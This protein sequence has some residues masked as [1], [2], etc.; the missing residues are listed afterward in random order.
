MMKF[1][2]VLLLIICDGLMIGLMLFF[3]VYY[4]FICR[5]IFINYDLRDKYFL[6][7]IL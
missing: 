2:R 6:L 1:C 4:I 7:L 5:F 3:I